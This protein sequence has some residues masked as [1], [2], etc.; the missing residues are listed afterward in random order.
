M[1]N[2]TQINFFIKMHNAVHCHRPTY[3]SEK[4]KIANKVGI[5]VAF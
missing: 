3:L 1:L 4:K 2:R 5:T